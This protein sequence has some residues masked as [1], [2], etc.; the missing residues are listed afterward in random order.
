MTLSIQVPSLEAFI[1]LYLLIMIMIILP[2]A[3]KQDHPHF[4]R[5]NLWHKSKWK[6]F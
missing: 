1:Y 4:V 3:F 2:E 6:D 5:I